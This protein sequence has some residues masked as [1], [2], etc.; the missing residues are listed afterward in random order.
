MPILGI[1]DSAKSGNLGGPAAFDSIATYTA[2]G[3]V[4]VITFNS[5]PQTYKHLQL[6]LIARNE[7]NANVGACVDYMR[8]NNDS[9]TN[10]AV[11]RVIIQGT[12]SGNITTDGYGSQPG[13]WAGESPGIQFNAASYSFSICDIV[14]YT[15]TNKYTTTKTHFLNNNNATTS[16]GNSASFNSS[17]WYNTAAV[18]RIDIF[19]VGASAQN[20]AAGSIF[21]LYGIKG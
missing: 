18:S 15:N 5:I 7:R 21:A 14:D 2:T 8:F 13:V 19:P 9:G 16:N 12:S 11:H 3:S 10:Y 4:G 1:I 20:Y 17:V 6:R